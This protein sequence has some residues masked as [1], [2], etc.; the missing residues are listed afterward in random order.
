MCCPTARTPTPHSCVTNQL[1]NE[2]L[3]AR[4]AGRRHRG[5][6]GGGG[7]SWGDAEEGGDG[8]GGGQV[9]GDGFEEGSEAME[10][11]ETVFSE[12]A[13]KLAGV[14]GGEGGGGGRSA[15][16]S[17]Y[18]TQR[19]NI[20][21]HGGGGGGEHAHARVPQAGARDPLTLLA[22]APVTPSCS[23]PPHAP[24]PDVRVDDLLQENLANML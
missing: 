3:H 17:T 21:I 22:P 5:K 15:P 19:G 13:R 14:G 24:R 23:S 2:C 12:R 20:Y 6:G 8:G 11:W 1:W 18:G 9:G 7:R 10:C 16:C 4:R